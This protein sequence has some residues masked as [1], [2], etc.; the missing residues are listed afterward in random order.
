MFPQE[1][2]RKVVNMVINSG[3]QNQ[4]ICLTVQGKKWAKYFGEVSKENKYFAYEIEN[5]DIWCIWEIK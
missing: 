5:H 2:S 3:S 4:L 1:P